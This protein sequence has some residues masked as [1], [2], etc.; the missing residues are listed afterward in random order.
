M[1][2]ILSYLC[3]I[4]MRRKEL[5]VV[6]FHILVYIFYILYIRYVNTVKYIHFFP[7]GYRESY[8]KFLFAENVPWSRTRACEPKP[9]SLFINLYF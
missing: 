8:L 2:Q 1:S 5:E 3:T 6:S 4:N 7:N 9:T